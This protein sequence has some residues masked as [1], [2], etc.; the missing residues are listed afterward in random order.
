MPERRNSQLTDPNPLV[1]L[2][3]AVDRFEQATSE[4]SR[5]N[6]RLE[7]AVGLRPRRA[8]ALRLAA[9]RGEKVDRDG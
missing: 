6:N 7:E 1:R 4:L 8:G 5:M 2:N 9:I 3:E